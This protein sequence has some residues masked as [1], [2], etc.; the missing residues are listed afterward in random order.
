M[1]DWI[2][3]LPFTNVLAILIILF[4]FVYFFYISS[5]HLPVALIKEISDIKIAFITI[6]GTV[7]GYYFGGAKSKANQANNPNTP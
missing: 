4:C 2:K 5:S 7:I 1:A 3:R 6:M